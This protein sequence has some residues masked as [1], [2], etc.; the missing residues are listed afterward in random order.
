MSSPVLL[1]ETLDVLSFLQYVELYCF[2]N[3]D[4]LLFCSKIARFYLL[5]YLLHFI[6]IY[7]VHN[8]VLISP[9]QKVI[10]LCIYIFFFIFISVMVYHR[11]LSIV[12]SAIQ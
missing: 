4:C 7:L 8:V 5:V 12:P 1:V 2:S 11:V 6:E 9:V 10:Q 3:Y